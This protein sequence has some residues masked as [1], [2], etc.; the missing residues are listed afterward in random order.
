L[1]YQRRRSVASGDSDSKRIL[2]GNNQLVV[3]ATAKS[4]KISTA[5]Q[6]AVTKL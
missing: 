3:M 5:V 6:Q 2:N 4:H 1:Q